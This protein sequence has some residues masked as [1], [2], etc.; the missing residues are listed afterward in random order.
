MYPKAEKAI[1]TAWYSL[2]VT[3]EKNII[4]YSV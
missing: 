2:G 3:N 4:S 1:Y